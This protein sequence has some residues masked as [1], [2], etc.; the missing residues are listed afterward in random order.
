VGREEPAEREIAFACQAC[1]KPITFPADRGG[2]VEV[3]PLCGDYVDV[4]DARQQQPAGE[5]EW[6]ERSAVLAAIGP[7]QG[8]AADS[9]N[10]GQLWF[11]V[12]AVLCLAYFP[13][14]WSA[15][16]GVGAPLPAHHFAAANA[17]Y[18]TMSAARIVMPLLVIMALCGEP[19]KR[20][21]IVRPCWGVDI[22]GACVIWL[23]ATCVYYLVASLTPPSLLH[24]AGWHRLAHHAGDE[25]GLA[26]A[27][28][29][30]RYLAGAFSEELVMRGYLIPRLERLLGSSVAAVLLTALMFGSYHIYQGV[31][32]A[33][34]IIGGGIVYGAS[35][36][37]LR[38]LWPIWL[39]HALQ[40]ILFA[41]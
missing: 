9:R 36:C 37:L 21:G 28:L 35:F 17:L 23:C 30:P 2:H 33:I 27:L 38:R 39:A 29:V 32:P 14:L 31:G 4:P 25:G 34:S 6:A 10:K 7:S 12:L 41:M 13:Y 11:E 26:C 24:G 19:W 16:D 20:F 5:A 40:N 1:G 18:R 3:C 22:V 15:V 8:V